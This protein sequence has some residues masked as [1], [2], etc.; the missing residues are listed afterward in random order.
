MILILLCCLFWRS[1]DSWSMFHFKSIWMGSL[2]N[3]SLVGCQSR[4]SWTT[5]SVHNDGIWR[6]SL[7][8]WYR[9]F[10]TFTLCFWWFLILGVGFKA[11]S[12]IGRLVDGIHLSDQPWFVNPAWFINGNPEKWQNIYTNQ[13]VFGSR[14]AISWDVNSQII[15]IHYISSA[16]WLITLITL[17]TPIRMKN[18]REYS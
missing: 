16:F 11:T 9:S 15:S 4:G 8:W 14:V 1:L 7:I 10:L 17:I 12:L 18:P 13:G 5:S 2:G 6:K 3:R